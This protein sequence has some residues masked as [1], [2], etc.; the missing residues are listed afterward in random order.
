MNEVAA[1]TR[2]LIEGL[3]QPGTIVPPCLKAFENKL[4]A[5]KARGNLRNGTKLEPVGPTLDELP[6]ARG[7]PKKDAKS[8]LISRPAGELWVEAEA[9]LGEELDKLP[10]HK[11]GGEKGVGRR[12]MQSQVG[13]AFP[14]TLDELGI[15]KKPGARCFGRFLAFMPM[16]IN[17]KTLTNNL[18]ERREPENQGSDATL[19]SQKRDRAYILA[20]RDRRSWSPIEPTP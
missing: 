4:A 3:L 20:F 7:R 1:V 19:K 15:D 11:G 18:T 2:R 5:D 8:E 17:V 12:G 16:G 9:K 14:P 10:K 13:T 6:E